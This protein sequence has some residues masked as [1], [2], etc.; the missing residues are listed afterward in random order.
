MSRSR[1]AFPDPACGTQPFA[2]VATQRTGSTLLEE[3][4]SDAD[5]VHVFPELLSRE[6]PHHVPR[7]AIGR[8]ALDEARLADYQSGLLA[9]T[10]AL[11]AEAHP[12]LSAIGFHLMWNQMPDATLARL[13]G[14][15]YRFVFLERSNL[16]CVYRSAKFAREHGLSHVR[17]DGSRPEDSRTRFDADEF[18][19]FHAKIGGFY[20]RRAAFCDARPGLC[21]TLRYADLARDPLGSVNAVRTHLGLSPVAAASSTLR[22]RQSSDPLAGFANP[23]KAAEA[24]RRRGLDAYLVPEV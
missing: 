20:A 21:V 15:A 19:R 18:D 24:L 3:L 23:D 22:K 4:L 10:G 2:L 13:A 11:H 7:A 9:V 14:Q 16:L 5:D 12:D 1:G 6:G 17:G 8:G